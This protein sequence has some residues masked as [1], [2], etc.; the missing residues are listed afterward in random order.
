MSQHLT[1]ASEIKGRIARGE[2][3]RAVFLDYAKRGE[4]VKAAQILASTPTRAN[5]EKNALS[6]KILLTIFAVFAVL[7]VITGLITCLISDKPLYAGLISG[8]V[9]YGLTFYLMKNGNPSGFLMAVAVPLF[10]LYHFV[11]DIYHQ[12]PVPPVRYVIFP[13][14]V[15]IPIYASILH[16]KLNPKTAF[17]LIPKRNAVGEPDFED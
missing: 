13:F 14:L 2:S 15:L 4:P 6:L 12:M 7:M 1:I 17:F 5:M 16:L 3:K 9:I 11:A 10:Y 8:A